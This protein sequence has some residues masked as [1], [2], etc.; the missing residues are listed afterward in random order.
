MEKQVPLE[1][2]QG[3]QLSQTGPEYSGEIYQVMKGFVEDVVVVLG[4]VGEAKDSEEALGEGRIVDLEVH[5]TL[6]YT[7]FVGFMA[8]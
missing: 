1:G 7:A 6:L 4:E 2:C 8:T 5:S 3:A